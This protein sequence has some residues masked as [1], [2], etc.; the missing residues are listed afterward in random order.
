MIVAGGKRRYATDRRS[1]HRKSCALK[2]DGRNPRIDSAQAHD[3]SDEIC[4]DRSE[5][6]HRRRTQRVVPELAAFHAAY[7]D[8]RPLGW[9]VNPE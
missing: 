7:F 6:D 3:A 4:L 1:D 9:M 2:Q 5:V 8:P